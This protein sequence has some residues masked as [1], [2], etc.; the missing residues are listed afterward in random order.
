MNTTKKFLTAMQAALDVDDKELAELAEETAR[1]EREQ[2]ADLAEHIWNRD[3][4]EE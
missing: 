2:W 3:F 1:E 4:P